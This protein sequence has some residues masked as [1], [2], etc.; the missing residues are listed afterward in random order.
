MRGSIRKRGST[1]SIVYLEPLDP[2]TGKR[3]QR[4]KGGFK[5]RAEATCALDDIVSRQRNGTYITP[6]NVTVAE[7]L[8][9]EWLP[10]IAASVRPSTRLSYAGNVRLHVIPS[11]GSMTLQAL[12]PSRV[13]RLYAQLLAP[14][15]KGGKG[16]SPKTVRNV[17]A[18]L[19]KALGDAERWGLVPRNVIDLAEQPKARGLTHEH[20]TWTPS[21]LHMFLRSTENQ[22]LRGLWRLAAMTGMRRGEVLGLRW[23]DLD[24]DVKQLS[25]RQTLISVSYKIEFSAPKTPRSR[26]TI[27]LDAE[28]V[29]SLRRHRADQAKERLAAGDMYQ[30]RDLV[31]A[32]TDGSPIHPDSVTGEFK[33][34]LQR[35]GLP[36][37][38]LHDLRHTYAT[39]SLQAR[40]PSKVVSE[41]LGHSTVAFTEDVYTHAIPA[42][43]EEAVNLVARLVAGAEASSGTV[44]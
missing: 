20:A 22:R 5:T 12:Q 37:I 10:A 32:H 29:T 39:M 15:D 28:T 14:T 43:Q 31:F 6:S 2:K 42:L 8:T 24:L 36:K 17:H 35:A 16:L 19:R 40:V 4:W 23:H 34:L 3:R 44:R 38:R 41:L 7:F 21:E 11:I 13:N 33:R 25:V 18:V 26:R 9:E 30:D 27:P 1:W